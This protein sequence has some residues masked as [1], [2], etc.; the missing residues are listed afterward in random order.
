M[1]IEVVEDNPEYVKYIEASCGIST[2]TRAYDGTVPDQYN[3]RR[4][5]DVELSEREYQKI[6]EGIVKHWMEEDV[7]DN[8]DN[9]RL[10]VM[11]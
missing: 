8:N 11:G 3:F 4:V 9:W 7:P 2:L 1:N 6:K 10:G 5:I